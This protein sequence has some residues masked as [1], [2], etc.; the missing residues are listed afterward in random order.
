MANPLAPNTVIKLLCEIDEVNLLRRRHFGRYRNGMTAAEHL[1]EEGQGKV[2]RLLEDYAARFIDLDPPPAVDWLDPTPVYLA[3]V[4]RELVRFTARSG[5]ARAERVEISPLVRARTLDYV[6]ARE[7]L[8]GAM[9]WALDVAGRRVVDLGGHVGAFSMMAQERGAAS[10]FGVEAAPESARVYAANVGVEPIAAAVDVGGEPT[11]ELHLSTVNPLMSS[12][13]SRVYR[14]RKIT[15]PTVHPSHVYDA[16]GGR[17]QVLKVDVEGA[18]F[19][20]LLE[21]A[22][23]SS[24]EQ[25]AAEFNPR[26][27][28]FADRVDQ[29]AERLEARF[30]GWECVKE[31]NFGRASG[32]GRLPSN[33]FGVWRR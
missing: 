27:A 20:V 4:S 15:V 32:S 29:L 6:A 26:M 28:A 13:H 10:V 25:V 14:S 31:P 30:A 17:P 9:Y 11:I 2:G 23:P 24:V 18:E 5:R 16:S 21:A 19:D 1:R 33:T 22:I 3:G 7:V 8:S 12:A